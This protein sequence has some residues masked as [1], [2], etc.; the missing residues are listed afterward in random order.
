MLINGE[1]VN[2]K[3]DPKRQLALGAT[4]IREK[5]QLHIM[6]LI[7]Q[8]KLVT[9][10]ELSDQLGVSYMTI[11]RDLGELEAQ[12]RLQ[13]IRGGAV[14]V[15]EGNELG[16][17]PSHIYDPQLDPNYPRKLSIGKYTA[18]WLVEDGDTI[19]IEA[20]STA[21]SIVSFLQQTDL[22]ILTNGLLTAMMVAP[23][24]QNTSLICSGGILSQMGAF[25]GPQAEDFFSKLKVKKAFLSARGLTIKDGFTDP[26][27]L[28]TGLKNAMK[29]NAEKVIMLLDSSK[30][31]VRSLVTVMA[32]E[33][34]DMIVTDAGAP[35][36][37]VAD[38]REMGIDIRVAPD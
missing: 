13:R 1:S 31:G 5:R 22:T 10:Q 14:I 7:K 12:G 16:P 8:E 29:Q 36:E 37:L 28:Y 11:S 33:E 23:K 21:T 6:E 35:V 32:L 17:Q 34:V 30:F 3:V 9:I 26:T 19:T 24:V 20:G 15:K 27:P 4:M 2:S 38:L 18:A 25:V